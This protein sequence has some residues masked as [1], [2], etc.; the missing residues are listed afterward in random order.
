MQAQRNLLNK[1]KTSD[2]GPQSYD[3]VSGLSM[4][5]RLHDYYATMDKKADKIR[6]GLSP[7]NKKNDILDLMSQ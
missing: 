3:V 6:D 4:C 5:S 1:E 2:P 7:D